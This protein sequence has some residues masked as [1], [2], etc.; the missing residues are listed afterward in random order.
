MKKY[1]TLLIIL[2]CVSLSLSAKSKQE[3]ELIINDEVHYEC[4]SG[5][6]IKRLPYMKFNEINNRGDH[7]EFS[8][9]K[10]RMRNN[11]IV[12]YHPRMKNRPFAPTASVCAKYKKNFF[13]RNVCQKLVPRD[14]RNT[15][16]SKL[17][18]GESRNHSIGT[19]RFRST[20]YPIF[21]KYEKDS[22]EWSI[23]RIG[24]VLVPATKYIG[25]KRLECTLR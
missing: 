17:G 4:L 14:I 2:N 11:S 7:L 19:A 5:N 20:H 3:V 25:V 22:D 18:L 9:Q 23:L 1:F 21:Y 16:C 13:G 15:L 6:C 24:S 8:A 12:F 10:V